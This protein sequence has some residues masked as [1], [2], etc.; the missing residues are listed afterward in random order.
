MCASFGLSLD[1]TVEGN[2]ITLTQKDMDE[3]AQAGREFLY[4]LEK[5]LR[6]HNPSVEMNQ[7]ALKNVIQV[8]K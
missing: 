6:T 5:D 2:E 8:C 4:R 1:G 7:N 3:K